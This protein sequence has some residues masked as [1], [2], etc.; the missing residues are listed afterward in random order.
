MA[1]MNSMRAIFLDRDGTLTKDL[2]FVH[3]AEDL[4]L[5]D[6][7]VAGLRRMSAAGFR[8]FI[9]TNQ[10]GIARGYFS[11]A[12]MHAFNAVLQQQLRAEG[13]EIEAIYYCPFHPDASVDIYRA[14]SPLRK[15]R[16]G[17]ILQAA[18]EHGLDVKAS[19][20]I[21][22]KKSDVLAGQAAGCRTIL[23]QTGAAGTGENE[24]QAQ[25]DY[26][27]SDLLAAAEW[28]ANRPEAEGRRRSDGGTI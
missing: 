2:G 19:F 6:N 17:M 25:S 14:D 26:V 18:A 4:Q 23:V 24:L 20:A 1:T 10:S 9:T 27:A 11:E 7:A 5:L 8:L 16:P 28:I 21:G 15:P 22:D 3:R 12:N 13:V